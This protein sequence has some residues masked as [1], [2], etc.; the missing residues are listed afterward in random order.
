[1]IFLVSGLAFMFDA[2]D[3]LLLGFVM[4]LIKPVWHLSNFQLGLFGTVTFIGMAIGA[5]AG[6]TLSDAIGRKRIFICTVMT[7]SLFSLASAAA[8]SLIVYWRCA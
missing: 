6:G 2:W 3:V 5:L 4:P 1:M 8:P 7:Y